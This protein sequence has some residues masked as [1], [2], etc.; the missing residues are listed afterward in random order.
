[1]R[2]GAGMQATSRVTLAARCASL[3]TVE[4]C[5]RNTG[6]IGLALSP[7]SKDRRDGRCVSERPSRSPIGP[8]ESPSSN[9]PSTGCSPQ[10]GQMGLC[11]LLYSASFLLLLLLLAPA[12]ALTKPS[13]VC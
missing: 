7:T 5:S 1:M 6:R 9:D 3:C 2:R 4:A 10:T 11:C 12:T 8:P 13:A